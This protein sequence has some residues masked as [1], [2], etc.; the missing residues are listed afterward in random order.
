MNYAEW[1]AQAE[2]LMNLM[3]KSV[4]RS[5]EYVRYKEL[6]QLH[7]EKKR[8]LSDSFHED[9]DTEVGTWEMTGPAPLS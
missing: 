4:Y 9:D 1:M 5:D 6:L 8:K 7:M 3:E 2:R